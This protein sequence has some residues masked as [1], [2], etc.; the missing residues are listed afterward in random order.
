VLIGKVIERGSQRQQFRRRPRRP[1]SGM[2]LVDARGRVVHANAAADELLRDF[3]RIMRDGRIVAADRAAAAAL[4][5]VRCGE[6]RAM[7]QMAR[8]R[9]FHRHRGTG[10]DNYVT[11]VLP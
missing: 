5:S 4:A 2:F 1:A 6:A 11:H 10:R 3:R 9:H 7:P 8:A